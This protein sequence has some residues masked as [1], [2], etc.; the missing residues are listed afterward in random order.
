M[1][2]NEILL[3]QLE[4]VNRRNLPELKEKF[5]ELYGFECGD[6]TPRNLRKRIAYRL[7]ELYFGG[8][9]EVDMAV[10]NGIADKDAL[11]NLKIIK[12]IRL[13]N[14]PG[15]RYCRVWR[16]KLYEVIVVGDGTFEY[17]GERYK[18]LSAAARKIT[19][20]RWNGKLFFG[21]R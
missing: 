16:G 9:S 15:T 4:V 19:G 12:A 21:V 2:N 10:L 3:R 17:K 1:M 18:S 20:S 13:T 6:T 11:A 7:Q 14:T 8:V 5:Q